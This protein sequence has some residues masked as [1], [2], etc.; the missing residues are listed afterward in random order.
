M[1]ILT[2]CLTLSFLTLNQPAH[3]G[4]KLPE[5]LTIKDVQGDLQALLETR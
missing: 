3:A 4:E 2:I 1:R 5:S